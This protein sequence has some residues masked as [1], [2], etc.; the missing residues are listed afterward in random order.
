MPMQPTANMAV[1]MISP[2]RPFFG[3]NSGGNFCCKMRTVGFGEASSASI[4]F[5]NDRRVYRG[6]G[7]PYTHVTAYP[8]RGPS[9]GYMHRIEV[10]VYQ[11]SVQGLYRPRQIGLPGY[12]A[13]TF[14]MVGVSTLRSSANKS[15]SAVFGIE[16]ASVVR[17]LLLLGGADGGRPAVHLEALAGVAQRAAVCHGALLA[18]GPAWI[19]CAACNT[20]GRAV[21]M[22]SAAETGLAGR[23]PR[24]RPS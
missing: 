22:L 3:I 2:A 24:R 13:T 20:P 9:S 18:C 15:C 11:F 16:H 5:M 8:T 23:L 21:S 1:V 6:S 10:S 4:T 17:A 19:E 14:V 12:V 7:M